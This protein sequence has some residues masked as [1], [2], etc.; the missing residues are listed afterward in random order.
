M[1]DLLNYAAMYIGEGSTMATEAAVLGTPSL[2]ISTLSKY[3]G[4][5]I[6]LEEQYGLLYRFLKAEDAVRTAEELIQQPNL[7]EQWSMK[8]QKLLEDKIDVAE[9]M[10]DFVENYPESFQRYQK[11]EKLLP[12]M[13]Q[14]FTP[15]ENQQSWH[16]TKK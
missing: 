8:R 2:Y 5:C 16:F 10:T 13:V 15:V 6:E 12:E 4:Y 3:L 11:K 9:F 1:H 14:S 7:K